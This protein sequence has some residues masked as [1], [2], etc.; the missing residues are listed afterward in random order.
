[1]EIEDEVEVEDE[2]EMEVEREAEV[3]NAFKSVLNRCL[4]FTS[5]FSY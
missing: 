5:H 4:R 3:E 1:M 2:V